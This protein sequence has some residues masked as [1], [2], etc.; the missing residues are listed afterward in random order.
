MNGLDLLR[1]Q[2]LERH[3]RGILLVKLKQ[4]QTS[5]EARGAVTNDVLMKDLAQVC[6]ALHEFLSDSD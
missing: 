6:E 2:E 5:C 3:Q 4:L 1:Q